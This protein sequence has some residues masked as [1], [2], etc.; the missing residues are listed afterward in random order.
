[1]KARDGSSTDSGGRGSSLAARILGEGESPVWWAVPVGSLVGCRFRVHLV[2]VVLALAL[3]AYAV[4]NGLGLIYV[5][6]WLVGLAV[7]VVAHEAGRRHALVR[8]VGR[9][10][11]EVTFWPLGALWRFEQE[12]DGGVGDALGAG[13]GFGLVAALTVAAAG[14]LAWVSGHGEWLRFDPI[15][16]GETLALISS[17]STARTWALITLWWVYAAGVYVLLF[18]LA[19]MLPLDAGWA[20]AWSLDGDGPES[21]AAPLGLV[22]A[23]VLVFGGLVAGLTLVAAVGVCGGVYCWERWQAARFAVDPAGVDR[24]REALEGTAG[25]SGADESPIPPEEREEV[26]RILSKISS[27]G[28]GSLTRAERRELREATDRL[29][30]R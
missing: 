26:E 15:R 13:A 24:W 1:M 30:G 12:P 17:A 6:S 8:W 28:M 23:V 22:L 21:R 7:A 20:A 4:W 16:P 18:N 27:R 11:T 9:R 19:P 5:V 14:L 3:L 2:T 25:E 10:P 29:R